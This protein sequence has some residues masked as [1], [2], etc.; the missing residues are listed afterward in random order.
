MRFYGK[1]YI[2]CAQKVR[3]RN[4]RFPIRERDDLT[5]LGI[6]SDSLGGPGEDERPSSGSRDARLNNR[7]DFDG[8]G[9]G[10][11]EVGALS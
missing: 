8:E 10:L 4:L 6:P 5:F 2:S 7:R 9:G 3:N 11:A 1:V